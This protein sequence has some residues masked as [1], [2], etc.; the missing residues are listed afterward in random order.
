MVQNLFYLLERAAN[1]TS[2]KQLLFYDSDKLEHYSRALSYHDLLQNA[3]E[4]A[5]EVR[6]LYLATPSSVILLHFDNHFDNIRWLWATVVAGLLP[7]LSTPMSNDLESRKRHLTHLQ[8]MLDRPIIL[9]TK[10]LQSDFDAVGDLNV[11]TLEA[12][13]YLGSDEIYNDFSSTKL[14]NEASDFFDTQNRSLVLH[15]AHKRPEDAAVLMLTSGSSG[16]AKA[17]VLRHRQILCAIEAKSQ[18]HGTAQ[19]DVFLNWIN[20]DHVANLTEVHLHAMSLAAGQIHIQASSLLSQPR[21]FFDLVDRHRVSYTFAP[22]FFLASLKRAL[23]S[24]QESSNR[25]WDLSCLRAC[26]SGGEANVTDTVKAFSNLVI[27]Y[28][29]TLDVVRPGFGMTE[30][31]AGS[32][33]N[34]HCPQN[35]IDSRRE[36]CSLGSCIPGMK[37]R[38]KLDD[39]TMASPN[40]VG[41]LELSGSMVFS[42]YRNNPVATKESFTDDGWF[43]TGDLAFLDD[44]GHLVLAGRSKETVIVNGV[45]YF[46]HELETAIEEA[47]IPGLLPSYTAVFAHRP[48]GSDT[49]V[50]VIVFSPSYDSSDIETR[51][52]AFDQITKAAVLQTGARPFAIIPLLKSLL[53][54]S[55]IGKLSRPKL[56]EAFESGAYAS[57]HAE[58]EK[59]IRAYRAK[60]IKMPSDEVE[61]VILGCFVSLFNVPCEEAALKASLFD[62][63]VSSIEIIRLRN[64]IQKELKLTQEIPV[65]TI[66]SNPTIESLA[67]AVR[68][69][70]KRRDYNPIVTLQARGFKTPIFVVHPGVGEV[71]VFLNLAKYI[72]DRPLHAIR[73]RGFDGEPYF[74][75]ILEVVD[76]YYDA[77]QKTQPK[78][79]YALAGYSYGSML[80]FEISKKLEANGEKVGFMGCF[81]LPPHIKFR[82]R[83][84]DFVEVLLNLSYFLD[85]I[86]EDYAHDISPAMHN[87]TNDHVLDFI[88]SKASPTRMTE[89]ALTKVKLYRWA[90]LAFAMQR[91]AQD[92]DPSGSIDNMDVFY[93]IPLSAVAKSKRDWMENH[94]SKWQHFVRRDVRYTEVDGT[95]YTMVRR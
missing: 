57:I 75:D 69:L 13:G 77:I 63:G 16:N 25:K 15:G 94:L 7:A 41:S 71:L 58:N 95:H 43:V 54:K 33:Y 32:I 84:L 28:K 90:E 73:A 20:L 17:V 88:I 52:A 56:R 1:S 24:R 30:T 21:T 9:T 91:I 34:N 66:I 38:V 62:W 82:M 87:L 89:M 37:M 10:S 65:I 40:Q 67:K 31:C 46:P 35:D 27:P 14:P 55:T 6:R 22:N 64:S 78:G 12:H 50:F 53:P 68:D 36:F 76:T 3:R 59:L 45:K 83:Q 26:I 19:E 51:V 93:A 49:E 8:H 80:A 85:L 61:K 39:G 4:D 18:F 86:S 47:D 42:E 44:K 29:A 60:R 2:G 74:K 11:K 48:K 92:Y 72:T 5:K 70:Q 81:N 79:P 23:E